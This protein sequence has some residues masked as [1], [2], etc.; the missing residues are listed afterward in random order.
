M[1]AS[2]WWIMSSST[3]MS[4]PG[5]R[6]RNYISRLV[7][8]RWQRWLDRRIRPTRHVVLDQKRIF[9]FP[10]MMGFAYLL[11]AFLLFIAGVNYDNSLILNFSFFLG[12]LFVVAILQTFSNLSGLNVDAGTT[13]PAFAGSEAKF[14]VHLS[15]SRRKDHHSMLLH[16]HDFNA[17]PR[18][19]IDAEKIVVQLLLKTSKRGVFRPQRLKIVSVYPLGLI[20]SWTWISLDMSCLVYPKPIACE[21]PPQSSSNNAEGNVRVPDGRD[22]FD[23]LRTYQ[24]TDP[25]SVVDWKAYARIGQLYSKRFH[26]LQSDANWL[27]WDQIPGSNPEL[28]LSHLCYHVLELSRKNVPFG[29]QIPGASITPDTGAEHRKRC[30]EVLAR[31]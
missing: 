12:S 29:L 8:S 11:T 20:Q 4:S 2:G 26:G 3:S 30:L 25:L 19:L 1:K 16:W 22:D 15:K 31:F 9:I 28:K 5:A 14:T 24:D 13:E 18:N 17:E 7:Q 27:R 6:S 23:G 21:L 10:T